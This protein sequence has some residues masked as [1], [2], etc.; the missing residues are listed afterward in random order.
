[1]SLSEQARSNNL[2]LLVRYAMQELG[3]NEFDY[4]FIRAEDQPF[5]EIVPTTWE[6]A[7]R[8]CYVKNQAWQTYQFAGN[9]WL[10][11]IELLRLTEDPVFAGKLSKLSAT[12]RGYVTPRPQQE[13]LVDI[14]GVAEQSGL[15]TSFI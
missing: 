11:G 10:R 8:R 4:L 6:E 7:K 14:F 13:Q 12:L 2:D 3:D 15:E 1:M 5:D 9:G